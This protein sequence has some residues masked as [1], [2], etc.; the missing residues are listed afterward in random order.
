MLHEDYD[1]EIEDMYSSY[2]EEFI[3]KRKEYWCGDCKIET[4]EEICPVCGK[5]T[6]EG[7]PTQVYWCKYCNS[8]I[9]H[10][11]NQVGKGICPICGK[12]TKYLTTDV[13]PV[14][15]EERL[16]LEILLGKKPHEL[17]TS[18]VWAAD[19]RYYID[20]NSIAISS[21]LFQT[22]DADAIREKLNEHKSANSYKYFN[23]HI[24]TF[25]K[26][27]ANRLNYLKT[28]SF[29]FVRETASKF[30]EEKVVLSF[31][32]GKDSTV[33]AD[34]V[35]KALSNPSLVHIF[36]NTTLEFPSTVTYAERFRENHPQ[37]IF[38][39]AKNDDQVFMDVCE[40]IGP[41]ARLM[42]WCCSMFKTGPITRVINSLY[43]SQQILTF[44]GIRKWESASRSKYNRVEDDAESV[45]I[46]Q[47][48]V[49]SPIFFWKDI[50][51]WLYI[52]SEE[53][54][55]NE[56]Y[57]LGYDR[58]GCW[59]CP[60]NNQRA[61]FLSRIY[62]PERSKS[63]RD[64]LIGFAKK[65]GKKDA[66]VYV[67]TG[68]W[69]ARQGGNGLPAAGDVKIKYT[70]CTTEEYAKIYRLVRPF[71]DELIGM[72]TPFGRV[73]PE[74]GKKLLNEVIVLDIRTNVAILSIQPFSQDGYEYA[75][76]VR[77]MNVQDHDELQRMVGYQIRKFNACRKCLKCES[78]CRKGAISIVGDSYYI[79]PE[80]C[81][82]CKM[83]MTAKYLDGGCMMDKYLRTK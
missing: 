7:V 77:T 62:M 25:I 38:L 46:Q 66:E 11:M 73:V 75:V 31:S 82:H 59:C 19:S 6:I 17:I 70:N 14:F 20:G 18:S 61:Q 12:K 3:E 72:F 15:P 24:N 52:L 76:K 35:V 56:A 44:Y 65:V 4:S 2:E 81:V 54:D 32:G 13:R 16:L 67:D 53:V 51:I 1:A 80:K 37:A 10:K 8:P 9:I 28:E 30:D 23:E 45:K 58:V 68:M 40:D 63:W 33:T 55:F 74:L 49:A 47:Q 50:D 41:P 22:A 83:C 57:R 5:D 42:R 26:A 60:N 48:T 36:G 21:E 43:R 29:E 69:K 71:D 78:I 34:V 64:F 79:D 27:N 39:F